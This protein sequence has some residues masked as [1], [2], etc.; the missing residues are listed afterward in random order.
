MSIAYTAK[1]MHGYTGTQ[2]PGPDAQAIVDAHLDTLRIEDHVIIQGGN[3]DMDAMIGRTAYARGFK[4]MTILPADRSKVAPDYAAWST[5]VV[6]MPEGTDYMA[7]NDEIVRLAD[8]LTAFPKT[9]REEVRSGT[10][11]TVRRGRRKGIRVE[12]IPVGATY[13]NPYQ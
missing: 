9:D 6:E 12:I 3:R 2:S 8:I 13:V 11:A 1:I 4:V 7:R 5:W 10:W